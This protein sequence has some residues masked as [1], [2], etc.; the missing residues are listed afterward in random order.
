MREEIIGPHRETR[1]YALCRPGGIDPR[2]VG[3][4]HYWLHVRHKAHLVEARKPNPRLPV[5]CWLSSLYARGE[6]SCIKLLEYVPAGEDWA[7]RE[8]HWIQKLR[9]DGVKLLNLT[10]GGEGIAGL[11][12]SDETRRKIANGLRKGQSFACEHC[13]TMFWR[14]PRDI[15][16]G[17]SRFC[18]R[19]CYHAWTA[20]KSKPVPTQCT[21][22]GIAA[23]AALRREQTHC[24]HGHPLS[25]EN[26]FINRNGSR[27][28]R[29]CRLA[30]Q[31]AS[32]KRRA[33]T[34]A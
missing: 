10:D 3:K 21:T 19:V 6:W 15:H 33:E 22:A 18:S 27:V 13:G 7:A 29:K 1:I 16:A 31:R 11:V 9:S 34:H 8:K 25:G 5:H 32:R 12:R 30:S 24:K 23:A 20:G 28:C 4:T 2:Y 14:K 17:N 26:L